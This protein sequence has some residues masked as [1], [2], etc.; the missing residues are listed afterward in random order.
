MQRWRWLWPHVRAQ[1]PALAAVVLLALIGSALS[2][3]LPYL[4]KL[5][6]DRGLLGRNMEALSLLCA[7]VVALAAISFVTGG[8]TRWIYVR[9]SAGVLFSLRE[10]VYRHLLSLPPDFYRRRATG[11]LVTRLDGD[12]AEI[13]RFSTDSALAGI[14]SLLALVG[15]AAIMLAMS[16]QLTLV[17][18]AVLPIQLVVRRWARPLIGARARGVR[19]GA[20][21][22]AQ[23]LFETLSAAKS[24]QGVVG[25]EHAQRQL[26]ALN[27]S[28]LQ[29]LLAL[30][31]VS[32]SV[33]GVAG[34][35]S[36]TATAAVFIYGGSKVIGGSLTVGTLVAFI[37]YMA[38]GTGS[39]TSLL[40]LY[41][42]YQRAVVSL[43]RVEELLSAGAAEEP[44][45]RS[46]RAGQSIRGNSVSLRNLGLGRSVCGIALLVDCSFEIP[47]GA[48][49]VIHG[50]SGVGKSL[51]VDAM[52]RFVPLDSGS[53]L[54]G[55]VD[56]ATLDRAVL[57]RSIEVLV[58]EPVIFRGTLMQNLRF[59]NPD[60]PDRGLLDAARRA[61]LHEVAANL[62]GGFDGLLG[63]GGMGLSTGQRQRVAIA[64]A[65]ARR[66][67][68]IV[69]DEALGNLD[70]SAARAL[71]QVIDTHFEGCTRII[72]SHS[73]AQ[74]PAA[75]LIVELR[76]RRLIPAP[77]ALSA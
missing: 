16:W 40:G 21:E 52:R 44:E 32:Y 2:I 51:L 68:V 47:A 48:K 38:R 31:W 14:N 23:F 61:G 45:A 3:V 28:Y 6:I 57:R 56:I 5:I 30:Q 41:T 53:I 46:A 4:S 59:G 27:H 8:V 70:G 42:A 29:R 67:S 62:P 9:A 35:L 26:Q 15:A 36:H 77:R 24:I 37:A 49:V 54:L 25:E 55:G 71:H 18:A 10:S 64:R 34:L 50:A 75:D 33:G 22:I 73:P 11:D 69:L 66:P 63:S 7:G 74:V 12:V 17:A 39:A 72:V 19:E 76:D 13:Q 65:L 43:E 1:A 60:V 20:G 58:S